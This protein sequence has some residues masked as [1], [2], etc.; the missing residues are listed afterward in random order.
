MLYVTFERKTNKYCIYYLL[1]IMSDRGSSVVKMIYSLFLDS[2]LRLLLLLPTF[3]V[4]KIKKNNNGKIDCV[5]GC[6]C[7][8]LAAPWFTMKESNFIEKSSLIETF[9]SCVFQSFV[10]E[11]V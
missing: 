11:R 5:C 4:I 9:L 10:R 6:V 2:T 3:K 7:M 8:L 1:Y